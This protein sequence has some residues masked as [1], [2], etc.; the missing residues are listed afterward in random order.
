MRRRRIRRPGPKARACRIP[1]ESRSGGPDPPPFSREAH[2]LHRR[3][4]RPG[5][6]RRTRW[7]RSHPGRAASR[8][9]R[10]EPPQR[11]R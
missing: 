3:W 1:L 8:T 6:R 10:R 4:S 11:P 7:R 5:H 2:G 9:R